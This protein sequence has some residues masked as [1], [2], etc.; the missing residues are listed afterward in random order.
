[1]FAVHITKTT[2]A[3]LVAAGVLMFS[4]AASAAPLL[5]FDFSSSN[6]QPIQFTGS[7]NFQFGDEDNDNDDFQI[8]NQTGGNGVL[9][10]LN[11]DLDGQYTFPDP[12]GAPSVSITT[13]NGELTIFDGADLFSAP[14][15]LITISEVTGVDFANIEGELILGSATYSGSNADL[16]DITSRS[17]DGPLGVSFQTAS[18]PG[19]TDLDNLF[20]GNVSTSYSGSVGLPVPAPATLGLLGAGLIGL[21]VISRRRQTDA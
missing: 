4:G 20:T 17:L 1:M 9:G 5:G 7:G 16:I 18:I 13:T 3:S 11:G 6:G 21:G 15:N 2:L 14:V 10:G 12:N 19:Q 8:T